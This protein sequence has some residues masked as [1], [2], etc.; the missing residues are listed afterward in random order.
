MLKY[1]S[2]ITFTVPKDV[3]DALIVANPTMVKGAELT[4][5]SVFGIILVKLVAEPV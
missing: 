3:Y 1:I 5:L 2:P 4:A